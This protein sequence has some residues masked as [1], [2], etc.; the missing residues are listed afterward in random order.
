MYLH[1]G[2][3]IANTPANMAMQETFNLFAIPSRQHHPNQFLWLNHLNVPHFDPHAQF[4]SPDL[5]LH[6]QYP[7]VNVYGPFVRIVSHE[8]M[9]NY[10]KMFDNSFLTFLKGF[11]RMLVHLAEPGALRALKNSQNEQNST[12]STSSSCKDVYNPKR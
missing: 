7:E 2:W 3:N 8:M 1:L 11:I 5:N 4:L 9:P 10:L 6:G 12:S